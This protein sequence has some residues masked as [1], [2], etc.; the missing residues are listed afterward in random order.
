MPNHANAAHAQ[1]RRAAVLRVINRLTQGLEGAFR[2][3]SAHLRNQRTVHGLPQQPKNLERQA[4]ANLQCDVTHESVA[5]NHI[6][7]AGKQ[8]A[9]FD[10]AD[11]MNRTLLQP[12]VDLA[13]QFVALNFLFTD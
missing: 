6:H 7:I 1:Q 13:R 4:F 10:I 11:K 12:R 8:I 2:K 9:A 3:H 5:H